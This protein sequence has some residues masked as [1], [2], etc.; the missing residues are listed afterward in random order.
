M[1][2]QLRRIGA[3]GTSAVERGGFER[4]PAEANTFQQRGDF[5]FARECGLRVVGVKG[6]EVVRVLRGACK[7]I[8]VGQACGLA[9]RGSGPAGWRGGGRGQCRLQSAPVVVGGGGGQGR[10]LRAKRGQELQ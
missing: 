4:G 6:V 3:E 1:L 7:A 9:L 5:E 2:A 8:G 10:G